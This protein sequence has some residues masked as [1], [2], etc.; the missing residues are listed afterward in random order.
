MFPE[1]Y[2]YT[3]EV[4]GTQ[5]DFSVRSLDSLLN[6]NVGSILTWSSI[7]NLILQNISINA[8]DLLLNFGLSMSE[9]EMVINYLKHLVIEELFGGM[10]V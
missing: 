9:A 10:F 3:K 6:T 8:N 4:Y 5:I 7:H 2:M 1:I